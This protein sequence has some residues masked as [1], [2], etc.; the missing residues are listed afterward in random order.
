MNPFTV[1]I[2]CCHTIL[3]DFDS[4]VKNMSNHQLLRNIGNLNCTR[5]CALTIRCIS[6]SLNLPSTLDCNSILFNPYMKHS[7]HF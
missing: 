5:S 3:S 7:L 1:H 6:H 4:T 2:C